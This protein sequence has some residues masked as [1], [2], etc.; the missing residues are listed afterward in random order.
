[1]K[2]Y[3]QII[4]VQIQYAGGEENWTNADVSED[5][6]EASYLALADGIRYKLL[7]NQQS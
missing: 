5:I 4:R 6:L 3:L 1:M 7:K 2:I